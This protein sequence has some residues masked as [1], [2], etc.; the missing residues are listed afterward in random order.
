MKVY[1]WGV[2][3]FSWFRGR[4]SGCHSHSSGSCVRRTRVCML[5]CYLCHLSLEVV[6]GDFLHYPWDFLQMEVWFL[7]V[8]MEFCWQW[9]SPLLDL[10]SSIPPD[11]LFGDVLAWPGVPQSTDEAFASPPGPLGPEL[12]A[13]SLD[14]TC[15]SHTHSIA[16]HRGPLFTTLHLEVPQAQLHSSCTPLG[17]SPGLLIDVLSS[18]LACTLQVWDGPAKILEG[19]GSS[20]DGPHLHLPL[21]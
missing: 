4:E 16:M 12:P 18:Q 6:G 15:S 8:S 21:L 10:A 1:F 19:G 17:G 14:G 20:L 7:C 13:L 11:L 9:Q 2:R 3:I 5:L